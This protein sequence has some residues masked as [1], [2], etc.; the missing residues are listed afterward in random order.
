MPPEVLASLKPEFIC[1]VVGYLCHENTEENGGIFEAGGGYVSKLRWERSAGSVFKADETFDPAAVGAKWDEITDFEKNVEYPSSITDTDF[2][3]LLERAKASGPNPKAEPLRFD[4]QVMYFLNPM[5]HSSHIALLTDFGF[6][7]RYRYR[8]RRWIGPC[9]RFDV[10]QARCFCWY[11]IG[12]Y[13]ETCIHINSREY[14]ISRQRSR[15]F[16]HWPRR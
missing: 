3:G 2:V 9:L 15:W 13:K 11:V 16:P 12:F 4:G 8:C 7:G 6:T 10:W 5:F 1:P 14:F